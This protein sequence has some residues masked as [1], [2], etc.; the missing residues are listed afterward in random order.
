MLEIWAT[1]QYL[2]IVYRHLVITT[3]VCGQ[4]IF[5]LYGQICAQWTNLVFLWSSRCSFPNSSEKLQGSY[6]MSRRNRI[7]DHSHPHRVLRSA[8][9]RNNNEEEADLSTIVA[10]LIRR[11]V[12]LSGIM[13]W[14]YLVCVDKDTK[15]PPQKHK[16]V[17]RVR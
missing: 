1:V 12:C 17:I 16:I 9:R 6:R 2:C 11:Y 8:S 3:S 13:N 14:Y 4:V 15:R 7:S 5:L 10:H